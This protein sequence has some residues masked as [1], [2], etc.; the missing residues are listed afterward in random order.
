MVK[1]A[2][3]L[4][5]TFKLAFKVSTML[6]ENNALRSLRIRRFSTF[7]TNLHPHCSSTELS[8]HFSAVMH[9]Y[10][11]FPAPLPEDD[12]DEIMKQQVD[13]LVIY[14]TQVSGLAYDHSQALPLLSKIQQPSNH[15]YTAHH[16]TCGF[17]SLLHSII[18]VKR[19]DVHIRNDSRRKSRSSASADW[20][21]LDAWST[22]ADTSAA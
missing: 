3:D 11:V 7:S 13:E 22:R 19:T 2:A 1:Q 4:R 5:K 6:V 14:N 8:R 12:C 15:F 16:L 20:T 17:L 21:C 10:R 9:V 18:L